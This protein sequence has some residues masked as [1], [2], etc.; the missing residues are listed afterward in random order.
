M[1]SDLK[2]FA[3]PQVAIHD[4]G[5]VEPLQPN[6]IVNKGATMPKQSSLTENQKPVFQD[7]ARF[8]GIIF[9]LKLKPYGITMSQGFVLVQLWRDDGLRQSELAERMQVATVTVSK[10]VDRLEAG[11]F[12]LRQVDKDDRRSNRVFATEKGRDLVKVLTRIVYEVDDIANVGISE[13]DLARTLKVLSQ[14]RDNL[15]SEIEVR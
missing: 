8:R 9:D 11:N 13:E 1:G 12:V 15:K 7:I 3:K 10:L 14:M 6:E 4:D 2:N 5:H